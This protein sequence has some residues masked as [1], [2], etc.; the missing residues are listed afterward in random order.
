M[1][2]SSATFRPPFAVFISLALSGLYL[3][4]L[5][6]S[7]RTLAAQ[8]TRLWSQSQME[9]F[10]KGDPQGVAIESDGQLRQGP[11]LTEQITTPSTFVWAVAADKDGRIFAA[12]GSPAAVLRLSSRPGDKPFTLFETRDLS[13][14]ALVIGPDGALYAA[15]LPSGRIYKLNPNAT[16]AQNDATATVVFD[17]ARADA[18]LPGRSGA[19]SSPPATQTHYIWALAFDPAGRLYIA[20]GNPGAI[21]RIDP[22]KPGSA[23]ELFFKTDEAHIRALAWDA[24]GNLIA[25]SDGSGLIYRIDPQGKGYVLFDA[26]RREITSIAVAPSGTIYAASVGDKSRN[27]LPPLP[28]QGV[29][30]VSITIVQPGSLLAANASASV[31]EGTEIYALTPNQAPRKLWSDKQAIVYALASTSSGLVALSGNRGRIFR[32]QDDGSYAD[33]AHLQAQ[34][35]LCLVAARA[36]DGASDLIV[37][38]GNTGKVY[39]LGAAAMHEYVSDILD[40]G[41]FTR[42]GRVE[43]EPDSTAYRILTRTGNVEQPVRGWSDWQPLQDGS[44]ASPPGRFLQWKADLETAG[45]LGSIGVDYLPVN[46]AP[47]VDDI[48]VVPG[49]RLNAST[50]A[51][52]NQSVTISF[53]SADDASAA[54]ADSGAGVALQATRDRSAVTV[55]WAAHDDDG[56][57]LVYALYLRGDGET[58]WRPLKKKI[59]QKACSFDA[60]R[61][62]DGGYRIKVVASD[63]PSHSPGDTLTGEK[64]SD[65]FEIDTTPPAILNLKAALEQGSC[66]AAAAC[67]PQLVVSFD[68]VDA[69]SPIA[70]AEFSLDA[71]SWQHIDPVGQ[72]SDSRR[73]HYQFRVGVDADSAGKPGE[74]LITV[75]AYD[76]YDNVGLAKTVV[77]AQGQ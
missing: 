75:R 15:T 12:T 46:A 22:A 9:Q 55:R 21:Y 58:V 48:V 18:L 37:G 71:G 28:V 61:I 30:A 39:T 33:I 66:A 54:S 11:G 35:G 10:E 57:D 67:K 41:A 32:I 50:P 63:A 62:P 13:V 70:R 26:P 49:A 16:A 3:F 43:V 56:D 40:A 44:V 53:P 4:A 20:A 64:V 74:Q 27:P 19:E 34:Q 69:Q 68:A 23:P 52:Q 5:V 73:E 25:G 45:M 51:A 77:P 1:S 2:G 47:V 7:P 8:G 14:Q 72:L 17:A 36:A 38:A 24:K 60:T 42:F 31:P 29:G 65:R 6:F 59:T 76:R